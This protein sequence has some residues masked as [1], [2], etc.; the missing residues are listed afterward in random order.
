MPSSHRPPP[1]AA[2]KTTTTSRR[3]LRRGIQSCVTAALTSTSKGTIRYRHHFPMT[4][5][6]TSKWTKC[7]AGYETASVSGDAVI[8][9]PAN[10]P[11]NNEKSKIG[12]LRGPAFPRLRDFSDAVW[13]ILGTGAS[14]V[15]VSLAFIDEIIAPKRSSCECHVLS[16]AQELSL[17]PN[18]SMAVRYPSCI[19]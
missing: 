19:Q 1:S 2:S 4:S 7:G 5:T 17:L 9:Q 15:W 11:K 3:G 6:H 10:G 16:T 14:V 12:E 13:S 8:R 18:H